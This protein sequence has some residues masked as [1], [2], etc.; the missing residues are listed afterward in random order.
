MAIAAEA[1]GRQA[2]AASA[3]R[4]SGFAARRKTDVRFTFKNLRRLSGLMPNAILEQ[5]SAGFAQTGTDLGPEDASG[6][7]L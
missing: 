6:A 3:A 1:R 4:R 7:P 5:G 2:S